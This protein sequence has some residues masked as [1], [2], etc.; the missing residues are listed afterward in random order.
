MITSECSK[1]KGF[2]LSARWL[3]R[4]LIQV[5]DDVQQ[6]RGK[7]REGRYDTALWQR[8]L[9]AAASHG[10]SNAKGSSDFANSQCGS[11]LWLDATRSDRIETALSKRPLV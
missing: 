9:R 11:R 6:S 5:Q 2:L 1:T 8:P 7:R 10:R 3:G 4:E